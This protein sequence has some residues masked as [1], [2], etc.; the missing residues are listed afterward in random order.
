MKAIAKE[1]VTIQVKALNEDED[2]KNHFDFDDCE[3]IVE[4]IIKDSEW[5]E[6]AWCN[7]HVKVSY[8]G[9][10]AGEYLGCCSYVSKEDFMKDDYFNDMVE[11]CML[12]LT[13]QIEKILSVHQD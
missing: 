3:A 13:E 1:N 11:R 9:L 2:P 8:L 12:D 4:K 10:N 5:N 7:A 6:W